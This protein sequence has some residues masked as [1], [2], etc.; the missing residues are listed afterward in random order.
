MS[1]NTFYYDLPAETK[2]WRYMDFAKLVSLFEH[3]SLYFP[4]S[5]CFEDQYEGTFPQ[6]NIQVIHDLEASVDTRGA[7]EWYNF[8]DWLRTWTYI[9]CWHVNNKESY[10]MWKLYARTNEAIAVQSTVGRLRKTMPDNAFIGVVRYMDYDTEIIQRSDRFSPFLHKRSSFEHEKEL[11]VL[12]QNSP[13]GGFHATETRTEGPLGIPV[14]VNL[15]ELIDTIYVAPLADAW[16][17]DLVTKI[18]HRYGL[19]C[20]VR[21]SGLDAPPARYPLRA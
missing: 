21:P 1:S 10:A 12:F 8:V 13:P 11:R 19:K 18:A 17:S 5:D 14:P 6:T 3:S 4:R 20:K 9:S 7:L 16:F 2:I 15:D